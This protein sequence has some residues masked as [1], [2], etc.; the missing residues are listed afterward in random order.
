MTAKSEAEA[1]VANLDAMQT[2][3]QAAWNAARQAGDLGRENQI[4][5]QLD[6]V[7]AQLEAARTTLLAAIDGGQDLTN[8]LAQMVGVNNQLQAQ[9]AAIA[10]GKANMDQVGAALDGAGKLFAEVKG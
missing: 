6:N 2:N 7:A 1:L 3:L 9:N 10:A 5:D 4:G 8:L